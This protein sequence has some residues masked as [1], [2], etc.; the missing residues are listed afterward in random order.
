MNLAIIKTTRKVLHVGCGAS[1]VHA[2]FQGSEWQEIRLDIDQKVKPDILASLTDMS[3]V[4]DASTDAVYSSHNLE[5]LYAHEVP[6]GLQEMNRVLKN[7]GFALIGVPDLQALAAFM[8]DGD[9]EQTIY[10]SPAGPV[11]PIDIL[12]GYRLYLETNTY[13]AHKTGFTAATLGRALF[14]AGFAWIKIAKDNKFGLWAKAYKIQPS[15][16]EAEK[17]VW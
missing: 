15:E 12:Y 2:L 10:T 1:K 8:L 16:E 6:L 11:A 17:P 3:K 7:D 13:M 5:H 9:I 4:A 14:K